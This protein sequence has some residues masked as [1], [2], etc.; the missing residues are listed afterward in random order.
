MIT[1]CDAF[2][3]TN[4]DGLWKIRSQIQGSMTLR[5]RLGATDLS[6]LVKCFLVSVSLSVGKLITNS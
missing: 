4:L 2:L 3:H 1:K 6:T 5:S